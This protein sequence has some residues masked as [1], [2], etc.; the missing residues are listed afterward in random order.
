MT[1][2]TKYNIN[3]YLWFIYKDKPCWEQVKGI[4]IRPKT[5]IFY[6]FQNGLIEVTKMGHEVFSTEEE[7]LNSL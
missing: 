2:E 5:R 4:S 6:H 7:L 3:D 1:I